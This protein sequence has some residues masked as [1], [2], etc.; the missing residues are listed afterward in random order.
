MANTLKFGNGEWYGKKDTILAYNDENSN[1][2]PLPFDFSRASKATVINKDGLIEEVGSGQPRIDY[3]DNSKGALLLEPQRT[4]L[5]PYSQDFSQW[6]LNSGEIV[7]TDNTT[8]VISPS[9]ST[10]ASKVEFGNS[11]R[12]IFQAPTLSGVYSGSIYVKGSAGE[13]IRFS[14]GAIEE[15]FILTGNWDR[16]LKENI[17]AVANTFNLNTYGGVTARTIYVWG[18]QLEQASYATSYIPTSGSTVT[19]LAETCS[20]TVPD[21]VIGQTEGVVYT[22]FKYL[23]IGNSVIPLVLNNGTNANRIQIEINSA[24]VGILY[25]VSG[26]TFQASISLGSFVG[27]TNYKIGIAYKVN[28]FVAYKNGIQIGSDNSGNVPSL[29]QIQMGKELSASYSGLS[30]QETKLY[31]TRLSNSELQ[32]L[33]QV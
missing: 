30:N 21:G 7:V 8:D 10:N 5:I 12:I 29:T 4:N 17:T 13:T 15:N 26:G 2:K 24:G 28:D 18:A 1:Y 27:N 25:V 22:E 9:G 16:I 31:N 6:S 23:G 20:Q 11:D 14:V 33:T 19:R 3:K 32:A